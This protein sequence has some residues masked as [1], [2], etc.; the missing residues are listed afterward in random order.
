MVTSRRSQDAV[1]YLRLVSLGAAIVG[2]GYVW[3][4]AFANDAILTRRPCAV[5]VEPLPAPTSGLFVFGS[6][7]SFWIGALIGRWRHLS[8]LAGELPPKR[9][10]TRFV[11]HFLLALFFALAVVLLAYEA[12]AEWDPLARWPITS[13]VRCV[14]RNQ[15]LYALG[16]TCALLFLL[17]QWLWHPWDTGNAS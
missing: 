10:W 5:E 14:G 15:T 1:H 2:L 16:T 17:G 12:W 8:G 11:V 6:L 3:F 9:D 4:V 7:A 13:F